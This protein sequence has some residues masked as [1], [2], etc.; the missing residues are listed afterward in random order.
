MMPLPEVEL[1]VH[2]DLILFV[3]GLSVHMRVGGSD[4]T[5]PASAP[6]LALS[7]FLI[8]VTIYYN[9]KVQECLICPQMDE[10]RD[11]M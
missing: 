6:G 11:G 7:S 1:C 10:Y 2:S 8:W 9:K 4:L 3:M 5:T